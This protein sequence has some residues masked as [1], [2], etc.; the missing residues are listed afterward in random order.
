MT[1]LIGQNLGQYEILGEIAKGGMST[2]YRAKQTSMN[3][4]VAIKILPASFMHDSTF[5]DRFYRE[6]DIIAHLQHPHILP[7]YDFGNF[8]NMPYI[9]MAYLSGGTLTDKIKRQG[10]ME[11]DEVLRITK[12]IADALDYAHSKGI[13]HRDFKPGNVLLD[14]HANTYLAD[15]GLAKLRESDTQ[16]TMGAAMLGTPAYM[17]PEQA[18]GSELTPAAD[19]YSFGVTI[20]QMLTGRVPFEGNTTGVLIAHATQPV[21]NM[22]EIRATLAEGTQAV[23]YKAMA[24]NPSDRYV[25]AGEMAHALKEAVEGVQRAVAASEEPQPALLMTNMLGQVIFVDHHCLRMLKQAQSAARTIMGK[26]LAEVL[27]IPHQEAEKLVQTVSKQGRFDGMQLTVMDAQGGEL[28]V[29]CSAVAT[30]DNNKS[31]VG[32]DFTL[33]PVWLEAVSS[34]DTPSDS[35]QLNSTGESNLQVYFTTQYSALQQL[36][37]QLG[38]RRVSEHLDAVINETASRNVWPV[39]AQGGKLTIDL[40]SSD[41]DIYRALLA[42]SVTYCNSVIG[43]RIVRKEMD[44]VDAGLNSQILEYVKAYRLR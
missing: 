40:K 13:I 14:D 44:R 2:V 33:K 39:K 20:F 28:D 18:D 5:L 8:E 24:K 4:E 38:G 26:T 11:L 9:V 37:Q 12:E 30:Y 3:R 29:V 16:I 6:V 43:E 1:D 34:G 21:P 36:L 10:A 35:E 31:F 22:R 23:I 7:V 42:K 25:T 41:A 19:I 27:G 17:S 15:F 32:A